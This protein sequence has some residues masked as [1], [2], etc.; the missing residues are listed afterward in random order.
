MAA[1]LAQSPNRDARLLVAVACSLVAHL[2]LLF[3]LSSIFD[4]ERSPPDPAKLT[5]R[6]VES[7]PEAPKL[8]EPAPP[9]P[10]PAART[11]RAAPRKPAPAPSVQDV[12]LPVIAVPSTPSAPPIVSVP[13][14]APAP[15]AAAPAAISGQDP[16]SVKLY[17]SSLALLAD[18]L[19]IYP[20]VARDNNWTG[21]VSLRIVVGANGTISSATISKS[22]GYLAL[23]QEAERMFRAALAKLPV[24]PELRG[25]E[26]ALHFRAEFYFKE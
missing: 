4:E 3:G 14:P 11:V 26:F 5:A 7:K 13:A 25:R 1:V 24:P 8:A 10:V 12:A 2:G 23:D 17:Q 20:R 6:L 15:V 19:K 22:A 16:A 21:T 9:A 18:G